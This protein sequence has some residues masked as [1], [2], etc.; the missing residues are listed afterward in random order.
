MFLWFTILMCMVSSTM[1]AVQHPMHNLTHPAYYHYNFEDYSFEERYD[2]EYLKGKH[3]ANVY[4]AIDHNTEKTGDDFFQRCV[5]ALYPN[6]FKEYELSSLRYIFDVMYAYFD[7]DY[8]NSFLYEI[9]KE[10]LYETFV[11][12]QHD[13][14]SFK[15]DIVH[16]A[17]R[18]VHPVYDLTMAS[19]A[20]QGRKALNQ[21][22]DIINDLKMTIQSMADLYAS[23]IQTK[24]NSMEIYKANYLAARDKLITI[25][26]VYEKNVSN[27]LKRLTIRPSTTINCPAG[28]YCTTSN[29]TA[30]PA[31][32]FQ[33]KVDMTS[34]LA[35]IMTPLQTYSLAGAKNY[36][37]CASNNHM[38]ATAC[39]LRSLGEVIANMD[40]AGP[41]TENFYISFDMT[42][43][44]ITSTSTLLNL[45]QTA[46][47]ASTV[48]SLAAPIQA[49]VSSGSSVQNAYQTVLLGV[50]QA[51]YTTSSYSSALQETDFQATEVVGQTNLM[52]WSG[53][54]IDGSTSYNLTLTGNTWSV[55]YVPTGVAIL[56]G[57]R[58]GKTLTG[59]TL[60]TR[61]M[62]EFPVSSALAY[63][64]PIVYKDGTPIHS[65]QL[66]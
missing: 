37:L 39:H 42:R 21:S 32:T 5:E 3:C 25:K 65:Y 31:G 66:Q 13:F 55:Y 36:T 59:G 1:S 19:S 34:P 58:S 16:S 4:L 29:V 26:D 30:C 8:K 24:S 53:P 51:T 10:S 12:I 56:S 54:Y 38:G 9:T 6:A 28:H 57:T 43:Q 60:S 64:Y 44:F 61:G 49:L 40:T 48:G 63:G 41:I 45:T 2:T 27:V 17:K 14:S 7:V 15:L 47:A 46:E 18:F 62:I 52:A 11:D 33:P 50:F 20:L 22:L 23:S 35:C